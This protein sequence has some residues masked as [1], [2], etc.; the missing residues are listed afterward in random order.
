MGC[1]E[2]IPPVLKA[3]GK[4]KPLAQRRCSFGHPHGTL[5]SHTGRLLHSGLFRLT[6]PRMHF[7]PRVVKNDGLAHRAT[8]VSHDRLVAEE[9]T[10]V[11]FAPLDFQNLPR[12]LV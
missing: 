9:G 5:R 10:P 2:A 12:S 3:T 8:Q 1:Y 6:R 7:E 11:S 4:V